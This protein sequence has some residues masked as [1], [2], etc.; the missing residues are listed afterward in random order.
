MM[1]FTPGVSD[2][3]AT[4]GADADL[5]A[6]G[7]A[8]R[9]VAPA[10]RRAASTSLPMV[11]LSGQA[12]VVSSTSRETASALDLEVLH[13]PQADEVP[14][15]LGVHHLAKCRHC[16]VERDFHGGGAI[17]GRP[18]RGKMASCCASCG[19][20]GRRSGTAGGSSAAPGSPIWVDCSPEPENLDWLAARFGF[21]PLALE[22]AAHADQRSKFEDYP[23][24][25]FIVLHR[26]S[27]SHPDGEERRAT[28][29]CTPSSP[30]TRWSPSTCDRIAELD[31]DL[32]PGDGRPGR[33]AARPRLRLYLR[34]RRHHR[35]PLRARRRRS[36]TR[37]RS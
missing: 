18:G 8:P 27:A 7:D 11:S 22:D 19:S 24:T 10:P 29:N 5:G 21:H 6:P 36:P 15:E 23:G 20:R 1:F 26:L 33:P 2:D 28:R 37:S 34:L 4:P 17:A 9:C 12:G 35:R 31:A 14:V 30:P 16:A 3:W 25:A 32:R 13:H